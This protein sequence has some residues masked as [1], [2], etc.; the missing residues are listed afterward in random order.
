MLL[1]RRRTVYLFRVTVLLSTTA[2][3]DHLTVSQ[4][5]TTRHTACIVTQRTL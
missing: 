4:H 2:V 3:V 5:D 1:D